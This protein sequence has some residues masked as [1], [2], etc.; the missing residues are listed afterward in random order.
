MWAGFEFNPLND[1]V[2]GLQ[3]NCSLDTVMANFAGDFGT[4]AYNKTPLGQRHYGIIGNAQYAVC[5]PGS[6]M[7]YPFCD[8]NIRMMGELLQSQ[9]Y[10][11]Q[12]PE[13]SNAP[14]APTYY[15]PGISANF[16]FR[17]RDSSGIAHLDQ[18]DAN[19]ISPYMEFP[20]NA[21]FVRNTFTSLR[22]GVPE[23]LCY[24]LEGKTVLGYS[25]ARL[26]G[27]LLV[28]YADYPYSTRKPLLWM[29]NEN[30]RNVW[31]SVHTRD[32]ARNFAAILEFTVD[33]MSIITDSSR[34]L[35]VDSLP[36]VRLQVTYKPARQKVLPY[37][38]FNTAAGSHP[39]NPGWYLAL[40]TTITLAIYRKLSD[41]W[42]SEDVLNGDPAGPAH[43]WHFKQ[44]HVML[45]P[46][47][48][49][50]SVIAANISYDPEGRIGNPDMRDQFTRY[51][52]QD[53]IVAADARDP[54]V[55]DTT[56]PALVEMEILS[57]FRATVRV[58]TLDLED[59]IADRFFYRKRINDTLTH[60]LNVDGS[61]GGL[62]DSLAATL[63][64]MARQMPVGVTRE[65]M[66][67]DTPDQIAFQ[68]YPA[69]GL[70]EYLASHRGKIHIHPHEQDAGSCV[71]EFRR[72][73][74]SHDATPPSMYENEGSP[75]PLIDATPTGGIV[76]PLDYMYYGFMGNRRASGSWPSP[77]DWFLS[78][79][80]SRAPSAFGGSDSAAMAS[81]HTYTRQAAGFDY[82]LSKDL[83]GCAY[84]AM[85]HPRNRRFALEAE[86][87]WGDM[88]V[89]NGRG[90]PAYR[91]PG[92]SQPPPTP[93][94]NTALF[95]GALANGVGSFSMGESI[96][97]GGLGN[98]ALGL[99]SAPLVTDSATLATPWWYNQILVHD[100]NWGHQRLTQ[101]GQL[102]IVGYSN[103]TIPMRSTA[104]NLD[105][106]ASAYY[107]G[108]SNNY[109]SYLAALRRIN[110]IYSMLNGNPYPLK[111]FTWLD[112]YS[113]HRI[114]PSTVLRDPM[115]VQDSTTYLKAFLKLTSTEKVDRWHRTGRDSAYIDLN[116]F[117]STNLT[118]AEVGLFEDSISPSKVNFAAIVV[119]TRTFPALRDSVDIHYYN[120]GLDSASR[121]H[122]TMGDI[123]T[124]KFFIKIDTNRLPLVAR[125]RYYIVRD[126]EHR[127][128]SW[129]VRAGSV[130][131]FYLKPGDA[132]FLYIEKG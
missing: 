20:Q 49:M 54:V 121:C 76:F 122:S 111:Q 72:E 119:N 116:E 68:G 12:L 127:N 123:D 124:R 23:L 100:Y 114:R 80:I 101:Y 38:P 77:S 47:K 53:S 97:W 132:K 61:L 120:D 117:D 86:G 25:D 32:T 109:R 34:G 22:Y 29:Q 84:A 103:D 75:L 60:S 33:T 3:A 70:V 73:K 59:S 105:T 15:S 30:D 18:Y 92:H 56:R 78:L 5:C 58:R 21:A 65:Y 110:A 45:K 50:R 13:I 81:Y 99:F 94:Q 69:F 106:C 4:I 42:R 51:V 64:T 28:T 118:F 129:H 39:N 9:F 46:S 126:I 48:S 91:S 79:L 55:I 108:F 93:E 11:F 14:N 19:D 2:R 85:H 52:H 90:V 36:L 113:R 71:Q 98:I 89:D 62:D 27:Q 74:M 26:A 115:R 67:I 104:N 125:S 37:V 31:D 40:D 88:V 87:N 128:T 66:I 83:R 63:D 43:R 24:G 112:A 57:T 107:L 82:Y 6:W 102:P 44:L 8:T 130:F 131:S 17:Y 96:D 95:F 10:P 1:S 16:Y 7:E 41:D 35:A